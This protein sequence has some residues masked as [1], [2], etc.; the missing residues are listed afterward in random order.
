MQVVI[1]SFD[2]PNLRLDVL[3]A[4]D[5]QSKDKAVLQRLSAANGSCI[6]YTT[7]RRETERITAQLK[8]RR[9]KAAYYHAGMSAQLRESVQ[10]SFESSKINTIV[11]TVAF[12]M[13]I[14]KPDIRHV[15]HYNLPP[16]L[17]NYY[18]EAGRAGRDGQAAECTLLYQA[19]DIYTQ[20]WLVDRNYPSGKQVLSVLEALR[21][22]L[23]SPLR[24]SE[25]AES[26]DVPDTAINSA[27]DLLKQQ[28]LLEVN[29]SG[30]YICRLSAHD[31]GAVDMSLLQQRR[32]KEERR[33]EQMINYANAN[34]CRRSF[35]LQYFGQ[36]LEG[37]C[38]GCDICHGHKPRATTSMYRPE[39]PD[40]EQ[41]AHTRSQSKGNLPETILAV[42]H[43][44]N[45]RCGRTTIA[46][47]LTG[48][49]AQ[50]LIDNSLDKSRYYGSLRGS[51]KDPVIAAI[52]NLLLEGHLSSSSGLYP[53]LSLTASGIKQ[54]NLSRSGALV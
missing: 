36:G 29:S 6:I 26:V 27:L 49:K 37:A 44:M 48:S 9:I 54:L 32:Q 8:T 34:S 43:E 17:E 1:G 33:L 3:Q 45:G 16:S 4:P 50:K 2:R 7:S 40:I 35:I 38:S 23:G 53:K 18:Q 12:G 51:K 19:K 42:V 14:D 10:H 15:I 52:D 5:A 39:E 11:C 21:R 28:N 47:I 13:G 22:K 25:I 46:G 20:R 30:E 24:L 41:H 31:I